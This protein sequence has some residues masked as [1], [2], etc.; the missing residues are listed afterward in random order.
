MR[1]AHAHQLGL[2][3]QHQQH[4]ASLTWPTPGQLPAPV[5]AAWRG[6]AG[7]LHPAALLLA[8]RPL[9]APR[10]GLGQ[11]RRARVVLVRDGYHL[12]P[13]LAVRAAAPP[14]RVRHHTLHLRAQPA[15]LSGCQQR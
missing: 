10:G 3:W 15:Q 2:S 9:A 5:G 6:R 14:H 12:R 11:V 4:G 7:L 8:T 13:P 1:T